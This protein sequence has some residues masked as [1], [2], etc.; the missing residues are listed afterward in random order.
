MSGRGLVTPFRVGLLVIA[1]AAAFFVLLSFL[2]R[3]KYDDKHSYKVVAVFRD[4]TGL[5]Q[6]SRVQIAGIEVGVVDRIDLT[7]DARAKATLRIRK[8]VVLR[9]DAYI[10]KR[11][12]SL[13][14]DF[15]LD[16]YPGSPDAKPMPPGSVIGKVVSQ[17][18][19]EDVFAALGEVT[20][21]IQ[22][23]TKSL[24]DLLVNDEGV[25]SIKEIIR[26]MN[27]LSQ[28]LNRTLE[29]SGSRLDAILANVEGFSEDVR[30]MAQGQQ[31]TVEQILVN[32]RTFTDQANR[33]L[34]TITKALE[35]GK[36]QETVGDVRSTLDDLKKAMQSAQGAIESARNTIVSVEGA[37]HSAQSAAENVD[38]VVGKVAR[39]EGTVGKLVN[40]PAVANR[41]DKLLAD[42]NALLGTVTRL[43]AQ[44]QLREELH[45][46]G[47]LQSPQGKAALQVRFVPRPDKHYGFEI[48]SDPR[49]KIRRQTV[50]IVESG[51]EGKTTTQDQ[52]VTSND[53]FKLS[54]WFGKRFGPAT[55]RAGLIE[56]TGGVGTDL[57]AWGDRFQ[58]SLDAFDWSNPD[59]KWPRL[60]LGA[61]VTFLEHVYVGLGVDD[62]LNGSCLASAAP[63]VPGCDF[64]GGAG[65]VFDDED[66]KTLLTITGAPKMSP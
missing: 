11:S 21:D 18:G 50:R 8:D 26:R 53:D 37:V 17:A 4:A 62:M 56:S 24:S 14:G 33:L 64:F 1:G 3:Q 42:T 31:H 5:G 60:R 10:T 66:L 48:G 59:A 22:K 38:L 9:V 45:F 15:L 40:D 46:G 35:E 19:V 2:A 39:G 41:I 32:A 61:R 55:L 34:S 25:G 43:Q 65:L 12:A 36:L 63:Q 58:A 47:G 27:E 28:G 23:M 29:R 16:I 54:A 6:K 52:V 13:L 51:P 44:V 20:R 57:N 7:P 49:G 30:G